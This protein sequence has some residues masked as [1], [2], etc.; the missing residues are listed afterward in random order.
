MMIYALFTI[1]ISSYIYSAYNLYVIY[2]SLYIHIKYRHISKQI[3]KILSCIIQIYTL[4]SESK[5]DMNSTLFILINNKTSEFTI[6][7][8]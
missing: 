2:C 3:V 6:K 5:M 1:D 8:V 7:S 4:F